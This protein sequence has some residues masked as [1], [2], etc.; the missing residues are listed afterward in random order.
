MSKKPAIPPPYM[1]AG[2]FRS[3]VEVFAE[4]TTPNAL[5]RHVL[6]SLSGADYSSLISGLRF[7]GLVSGDENAV[8]EP[9]RELVAARKKGKAEYKGSLLSVIEPAYKPIVQ[10]V[11]LERGSLPQLEKAF[12]D[13]GVP[14]GQML[15]KTVRFYI[16]TMIECG[17]TISPHITKPRRPTK[18]KARVQ[19]STQ[20]K[21]GVKGK[22]QD[23]PVGDETTRVDGAPKGFQRLTLPGSESAFIQYPTK[24]TVAECK[25]FEA[26]ITVLHTSVSAREENGG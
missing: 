6:S 26:M 10:G 12:R 25:I 17:K 2:L 4:S 15:I 18:K 8:Q 9:Y 20:T 14:S 19:K 24:L 11:D 22:G 3:T 23:T 16:K 5:D 21:K 1:S 7:L 13:A